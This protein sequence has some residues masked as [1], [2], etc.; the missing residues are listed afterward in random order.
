MNWPRP[1]VFFKGGTMSRRYAVL[2]CLVLLVGTAPASAELHRLGYIHKDLSKVAPEH[3]IE[4]VP[5]A[6]GARSFR[7]LLYTSPSPRD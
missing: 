1:P 2:L 4:A 5:V 6:L 7:C 3:R